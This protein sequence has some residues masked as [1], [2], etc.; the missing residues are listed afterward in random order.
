LNQ[1]KR[2]LSIS[3]QR[4]SAVGESGTWKASNALARELAMTEMAVPL[5]DSVGAA[6]HTCRNGISTVIILFPNY[7]SHTDTVMLR[8]LEVSARPL[9]MAGACGIP[10]I[11]IAGFIVQDIVDICK[12]LKLH[13]V[14]LMV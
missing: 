9:N 13:K 2:F 10:F 1:S 5:G 11:G 3:Y 6:L 4:Y 7:R 14:R 8:A 12:E